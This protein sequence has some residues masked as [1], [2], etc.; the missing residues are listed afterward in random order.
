M[1]ILALE[2]DIN[3]IKHRFLCEGENEVL[4]TRYHGASFL[5][6]SIREFLFTMLLFGIGIAA[7]YMSAPMGYTVAML[8]VVWFIFVFVSLIKAYIDW[9]FDF[10]F[11]TTEKVILVDQTSII[12]HKIKPINLENIGGVTAQTQF[13]DVFRFGIVEIHLKEG[14][15]GET[16]I[17]RYV[18]DAREVAAK[19]SEVVT[20][21]QRM[22][23]PA[24]QAQKTHVS[25]VAV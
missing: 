25:P 5:F 10:I 7:W 16:L 20:H 11:V 2:T 14:E 15:G 4:T 1:R 6:A 19:I 23:Y 18:P 12:R 13:G 3:K 24:N 22:H 21:Y 17:L 9:C 8:F